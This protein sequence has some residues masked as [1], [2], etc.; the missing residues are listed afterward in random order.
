MKIQDFIFENKTTKIMLYY[1][2][3]ACAY[4]QPNISIILTNMH[5][6]THTMAWKYV[7]T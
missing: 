1:L 5:A 3:T 4:S 6:L 2:V 7:R